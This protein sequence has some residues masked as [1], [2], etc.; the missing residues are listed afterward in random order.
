MRAPAA[1]VGE[2]WTCRQHDDAW[3]S[4]IHLVGD[5]LAARAVD[6]LRAAPA[7]ALMTEPTDDGTTAAA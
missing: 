5:A 4:A 7:P 1:L 3:Q 6:E 2:T